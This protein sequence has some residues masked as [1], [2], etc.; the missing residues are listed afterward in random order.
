M[1]SIPMSSLKHT[2]E[3]T[4]KMKCIQFPC[5]L[6]NTFQ[7]VVL[8]MGR[9]SY[10]ALSCD[11]SAVY[12][13][14]YLTETVL[15]FNSASSAPSQSCVY[16]CVYRAIYWLNIFCRPGTITTVPY[17]LQDNCYSIITF[18]HPHPL[19]F[20]IILI[21]YFQSLIHFQSFSSIPLDLSQSLSVRAAHAMPAEKPYW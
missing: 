5:L 6:L 17:I 20:S 12:V 18:N 19:L 4:R 11:R 13:V 14:F 8:H 2:T 9:A 1:H 3:Q 21:P 15:H 16:S 10:Q 7:T